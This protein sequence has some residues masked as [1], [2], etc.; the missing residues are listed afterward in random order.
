MPPPVTSSLSAGAKL[1]AAERGRGAIG[2]SGLHRRRGRLLGERHEAGAVQA[3]PRFTSAGHLARTIGR[4]RT[5]L[6]KNVRAKSGTRR[7]PQPLAATALGVLRT[8]ELIEAAIP[9]PTPSAGARGRV[10]R[11]EGGARYLIAV[12]LAIVAAVMVGG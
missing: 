8:A 9:V 7:I 1:G 6:V 10:M 2:L 3:T 11:A 5:Y 4:V 12:L